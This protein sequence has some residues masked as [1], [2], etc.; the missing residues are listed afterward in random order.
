MSFETVCRVNRAGIWR[1]LLRQWRRWRPV[2]K[3]KC[4]NRWV[5]SSVRIHSTSSTALKPMST[6]DAPPLSPT[7]NV[8]K[9]TS[10]FPISQSALSKNRLHSQFPIIFSN[11]FVS[12][13]YNT[14]DGKLKVWQIWAWK[15]RN[16][17]LTLNFLTNFD[18]FWTLNQNGNYF[19]A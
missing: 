16:F 2:S 8:T 12:I 4:S 1:Q 13:A 18:T 6:P 7:T 5:A 3:T 9:V 10:L 19:S 11:S 15:D 14:I 17:A